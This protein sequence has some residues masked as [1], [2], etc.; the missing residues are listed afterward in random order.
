MIRTS[1]LF[2]L[3]SAP[4]I[5]IMLLMGCKDTSSGT[6]QEQPPAGQI[7][8]A[9]AAVKTET[10]SPAS[11][12]GTTTAQPSETAVGNPN[13]KVSLASAETNAKP[14]QDAEESIAPP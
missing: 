6:V 14:E 9:S 1:R 7:S 2:T 13:D 11:T 4:F 8:P 3:W 10:V 5:F 12:E